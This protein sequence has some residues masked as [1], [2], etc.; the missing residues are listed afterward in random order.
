MYVLWD[1]AQVVEGIVDGYGCVVDDGVQVS[2]ALIRPGQHKPIQRVAFKLHL[3]RLEFFDRRLP[4]G[5][6]R[7]VFCNLLPLICDGSSDRLEVVVA[8]V[9]KL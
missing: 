4:L 8:H 2:H 5:P 6:A 3:A 7:D 1:A 9:V